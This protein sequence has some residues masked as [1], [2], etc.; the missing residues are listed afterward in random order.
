MIADISSVEEA[1]LQSN[2]GYLPTLDGWRCLA[3]L[4]VLIDHG[5]V[6]FPSLRQYSPLRL[7]PNGVSLFFAISGFLICTRLLEE[8]KLTGR[9]SLKG[10]YIRRAFRILPPAFAY[11]CVIAVLGAVGLLAVTRIEVWSS[12]FF[13][14]NYVPASWIT[15]GWG[16]YTIHFWS[17]AVEEHFYLIW[18]ALLILFGLRYST[19]AAGSFAVSVAMWRWWSLSNDWIG[20]RLPGLMF[21]SRT[22]IRLD[23]LL[24]GCLVA[25]LVF[26]E[27]S[28]KWI[29]QKFKRAVWFALALTYVLTQAVRGHHFYTIWESA[30]LA[31]L[32]AGTVLDA[33]SWVGR[34]LELPLCKWI[35]RLS[36]SL[37]LWQELFLIPGGRGALSNLQIFTIGLIL[38]FGMAVLSYRFLERPLIRLGH[39]LA[40]PASPGRQDIG[41]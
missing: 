27:R 34:F 28:G 6:Y 15:N 29:A 20:D 2:H 23:G 22:D 9:I 25:M 37:Y 14:R 26:H 5:A 35:G 40:K 11:V 1:K 16:G 41:V 7:G 38:T 33:N 36:Y 4:A 8:R 19:W 17:L 32:V 24:L 10:F 21:Y 30:I 12:L 18:P 13:F 31:L 39:Q 3:I